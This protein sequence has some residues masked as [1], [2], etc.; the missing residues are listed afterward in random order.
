VWQADANAAINVLHR[1]GDRDITLHTPH[2]AV[3]QIVQARAD[4]HRTRLPVPD[5]SPAR[6]AES[7]TSINAHAQV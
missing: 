1:H 2:Q 7:E 6:R 3:L 5:S 4:R